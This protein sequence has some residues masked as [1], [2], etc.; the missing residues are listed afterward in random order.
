M[1]TFKITAT[2]TYEG[3]VSAPTPERAEQLFLSDLNSHYSST[4]SFESIEV[5]SDCEEET[6]FC[7][8]VEDE[9]EDEDSE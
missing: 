7:E 6:A 1:A 2:Y 4:E 3:V 9:D 8:C 5:C